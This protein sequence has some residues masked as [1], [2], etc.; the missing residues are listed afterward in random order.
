VASASQS[1][2]LTQ[3]RQARLILV[4]GLPGTGKSTLAR[5]LASRYR[6]PI[7]AKDTIK[8]PLLD[9]IGATDRAGSR[10]LSDASFAILFALARACLGADTDLILEGNFRPGEH[11]QALAA[12]DGPSVLIAQ[13]LCRATQTVRIARL[14]AR[15]D[16]PSRH[17]G[18]HDAISAN[19]AP[20]PTNDFLALPGE[21][22]VF[23]SD[24]RSAA[25][26]DS[27]R[28][29]ALLDALDH[30]YRA[31]TGT[32]LVTPFGDRAG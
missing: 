30:W 11:E 5:A 24:A 22:F 17:P 2:T 10:R 13:V 18:H 21:R 26:V 16:D 32:A 27:T 3:V 15:A 9:L 20:P 4:T 7:L 8:E 25:D 28:L 12:T 6:I 14:K 29:Q 31:T 1:G 23:D 19:Y